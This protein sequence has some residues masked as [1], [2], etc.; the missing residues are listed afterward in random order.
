M[1]SSSERYLGNILVYQDEPYS[2]LNVAPELTCG[3]APSVLFTTYILEQLGLEALRDLVRRPENGLAALDALFAERGIGLDTETLFADFVLANYLRDT[4]LG[5]GRFG[6]HLFA[7]LPIPKPYVRGRIVDLPTLMGESLPPYATDFYDFALPASDQ[8][9]PLELSLQFPHSAAQDG[10]LQF[11]Q[12]VAGE[13]ILQRFRAS[14]HRNQMIPVTL[15]PDAEQ[16]FLA[17][18]PFQ[19][20]A[21]HLTAEQPYTLQIHLAGSDGI[22]GRLRR[23]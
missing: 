4:Q 12:V 18:S 10:W 16:A 6:Y 13:V 11:V 19:A 8:P 21:R 17:I 9:Q 3:E 22:A 1:W 2:Q 5:D 14:D 7:S 15:Q 20:N 23:Y